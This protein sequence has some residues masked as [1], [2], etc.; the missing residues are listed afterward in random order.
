MEKRRDNF[1][2]KIYIFCDSFGGNYAK[3]YKYFCKYGKN[4]ELFNFSEKEDYF[5][6]TRT[7]NI[8]EEFHRNQNN[9]IFHYNP[10]ISYLVN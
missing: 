9:G 4:T 10:K 5:I 1:C 8:V 3:L 6:N 2:K 7:N